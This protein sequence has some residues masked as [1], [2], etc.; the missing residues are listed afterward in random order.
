[1]KVISLNAFHL[2]LITHKSLTQM[3]EAMES[4][5]NSTRGEIENF[6]TD[7]LLMST[8]SKV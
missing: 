6:K 4:M 2:R 8:L 7:Q 3:I 1:M 5:A